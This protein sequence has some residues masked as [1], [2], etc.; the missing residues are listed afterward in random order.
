MFIEKILN[1]TMIENKDLK[2]RWIYLTLK[3]S[4]FIEMNY[5][6]P[7]YFFYTQSFLKLIIQRV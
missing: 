1:P 2:Y 4:N 6:L 7:S 3:T 5:N